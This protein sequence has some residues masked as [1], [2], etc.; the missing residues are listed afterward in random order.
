MTTSSDVLYSKLSL[1]ADYLRR[2]GMHVGLAELQDAARAL[3]MTGFEDRETV[4]AVLR[5]LCAKSA[6][7]QV[8]FDQCFDSFFVSEEEF[9]KNLEAEREAERIYEDQRR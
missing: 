5:A 3:N 7:E 9:Q 1:F 2:Q 8:A 4:K 6:R